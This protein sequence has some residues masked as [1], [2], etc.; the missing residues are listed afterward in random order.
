MMDFP[1][2]DGKFDIVVFINQCESYFRWEH[3]MEEEKVWLASYNLEDDARIW[4][5]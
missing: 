5:C 4:F 2:F 3:I 1:R